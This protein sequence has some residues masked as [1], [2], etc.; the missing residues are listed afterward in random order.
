M[1][2]NKIIVVL[3]NAIC[4][5][6]FNY[7]Q[8]YFFFFELLLYVRRGEYEEVKKVGR[9]LEREYDNLIRFRVWVKRRERSVENGG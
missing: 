9:G 7:K 1:N 6:L 8:I 5:L 2:L 3:R 4:Y